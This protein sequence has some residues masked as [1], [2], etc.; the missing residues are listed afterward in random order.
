MI[1][2][3][4]KLEGKSGMASL[5]QTNRYLH[6]PHERW[7]LLEENARASSVFEGAR[8]LTPPHPPQRKST[9]RRSTASKKNSVKSV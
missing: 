2:S 3:D 8:G 9:R 6:D 1:G 5:A 7:R 4:D